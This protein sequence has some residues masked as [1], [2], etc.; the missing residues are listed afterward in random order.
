MNSNS[1]EVR[2]LVQAMAEKLLQVKLSLRHVLLCYVM[3]CYFMFIC[4]EL[5]RD[6]DTNW[7]VAAIER[8]IILHNVHCEAYSTSSLQTLPSL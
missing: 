6:L 1:P 5:L 2:A 8:G 4:A 7:G 3:L